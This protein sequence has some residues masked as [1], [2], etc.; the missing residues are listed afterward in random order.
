[1][2]TV[3]VQL[4][5]IARPTGIL[6]KLDQ[7]GIEYIPKIDRFDGSNRTF[8]DPGFE[9]KTIQVPSTIEG[10][11]AEDLM[12]AIESDYLFTFVRN[13]ASRMVSLWSDMMMEDDHVIQSE[14]S[15]PGT[16][17]HYFFNTLSN[18]GFVPN[19]AF[20]DMIEKVGNLD[21]SIISSTVFLAPY[22]EMLDKIKGLRD[23]RPLEMI[24]RVENANEELRKVCEIRGMD[25][26]SDIPAENLDKDPSVNFYNKPVDEYYTEA[27]KE[28]VRVVYA[29]DLAELDYVV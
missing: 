13:P 21:R 1:M 23:P 19:M 3:F 5:E 28:L 7:L 4:P 12:V 26:G 10:V 27:T 11:R 20:N 2:S 24:G 15:E 25:Y 8:T 16:S 22:T 17:S 9:N 18:H 14:L 29:R 6:S